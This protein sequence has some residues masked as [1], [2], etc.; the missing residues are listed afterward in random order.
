MLSASQFAKSWA[1]KAVLGLLILAMA[2]FG[3]IGYGNQSIG[4]TDVI[5]A[6][7]RTIDP[8]AFRREYDS[9]KQRVE[10]QSGQTITQEMA[11]SNHL[12]T[13]VLNGVAAREAF[14]ALLS[15]IGIKPSD[16]QILG[17]IEKIPAFFDPVSGRFDKLTFQRRLADNGLTP[18]AFDSILRDEIASQQ[19]Q[20]AVQHGLAA[21]KTYGALAA[22]FALETRD[23]AYFTVTPQSV[24]KPKTPTDAQLQSFINEN[25]S[26]LTVPELRVL[27]VVQFSPDQAAASTAP[28]DPA[29]LKKR[30]EFRKDTLSRPE[31]RTVIQIPA[32]T[33]AQAQQAA[34]RLRKGED[35]AAIAKS[36]GVEPITFTD[37]PLSAIS[38]HKVGQAA[39]K[40]QAGQVAAVQG[41]LSQSAV[42]VVSVNPGHEV[43]LEEARPMLEAEI[44]KDAA[45]EKVY[46]QTQAY[47]DAHQAGASL[48]EA[49]QKAGVPA[50]TYPAISQEGIGAKGERFPELSPQIL[51][52]AFSLPAGGESEVTEL[53][54]GAYFAVRV[55]KIEPAHVRPLEEI[56]PQLTQFW[57]QREMVR[58]MEARAKELAARVEKGET[59]DA[60]AKSQG[61]GVTRI[62][63]LSRQS[64]GEHQELGRDLLGRTFSAKPGDVWTAPGPTGI[65]VGRVENVKM[66]ADATAGQLAEAGRR[67]LTMALVR[68]IDESAHAYA[69]EKMKVK[70]YPDRAR[71]AVGF[72]PLEDK[73]PSREKKG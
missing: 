62:A 27:T 40:M 58:A 69:R 5:K 65:V 23:L 39:F 32:K 43:T 61:L 30:Y 63:Q 53:G 66:N 44:R 59:L 56:R 7:S 6:G 33:Q 19:W 11:E 70:V 18:A 71:S 38:D 25:R 4:S 54:D 12:D 36:M 20:A 22:V 8:N 28:I 3:I 29:E 21:P 73:K 48:T 45:A 1:A 46:A 64:A 68:D 51:E 15:R 55:E 35:P 10:Q 9:Y 72:P 41:D 31:T 50:K 37:K 26:Q 2:G 13:V 16:K 52:T 47:D 24:P 67:D 49:A 17:Q 57:M 14:S 60:V 42:K 34:E